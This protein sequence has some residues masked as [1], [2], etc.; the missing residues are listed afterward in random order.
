LFVEQSPLF[1]WNW[2]LFFEKRIWF[3]EQTPLFVE[4]WLMFVEKGVSFVEHRLVLC[5]HRIA[6]VGIWFGTREPESLQFL[7]FF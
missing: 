3:V 7:T 4:N 6:I 1:F 2:S 5:E